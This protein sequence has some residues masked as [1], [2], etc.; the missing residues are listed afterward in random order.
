[1]IKLFLYKIKCK[2]KECFRKYKR[3]RSQIMKV[4]IVFNESGWIIH[5]FA[6]M[7]CENLCKL[8][9]DA[10]VSSQYDRKADINHYFFP[11]HAPISNKYVTFMITHVDMLEK[12]E[13]IKQQTENGAIGICMSLD[14]KNKLI[15]YGVRPDRLCFINP[16]QDEQIAPRKIKLGFTNRVYDDSR[17]RESMLIDVCGKIDNRIFKFCIMGSG[18]DSIVESIKSLGFEVEY[19]PDFDKDIYNDLITNLDY[20]CYFGFDEGSM[21]FLDALAAGIGTIVTPQGY[22]LDLGIDITYPVSTID[23]I[24]DALH[25]IEKNRISAIDFSK[26]YTWEAYAKKHIEI[27]NYMLDRED[28]SEILK[29]RGWYTDG[30]YSLFLK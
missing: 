14:T 23:D 3:R 6:C 25:E 10:R 20:Y 2:F 26:K 12:L 9:V 5:K 28:M 29:T 13:L 7:L 27:W 18:W 22:H 15:S 30:I 8:G 24:V 1:M 17:K 4:N 21:G 19:Y 11:N 16:A